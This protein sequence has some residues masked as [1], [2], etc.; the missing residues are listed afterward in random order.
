MQHD[1]INITFDGFVL[2][3][4]SVTAVIRRC[5]EATLKAEG[6]SVFTENMFESRFRHVPE[7]QRMG[8]EIYTEGRA[9][10]VR[11][12]KKLHGAHV[13]ATDLRG[14]AAMLI[15]ALGAEGATVLHDSGHLR[16]GYEKPVEILTSLGAKIY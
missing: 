15:A 3:K 14:S 10:I 12:V 8:G 6:T 4:I 9:A 7:L 16:R 1:K 5:I 13:S 11:G 2:Q